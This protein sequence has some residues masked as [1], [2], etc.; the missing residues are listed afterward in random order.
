[1]RLPFLL[2]ISKTK[3]E[4]MPGTVRQ[5]LSMAPLDDTLLGYLQVRPNAFRVS[6]VWGSAVGMW[7]PLSP[8]A[9]CQPGT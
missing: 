6:A 9:P 2:I 7:G 3:M 5:S 4:L 1:M 8:D